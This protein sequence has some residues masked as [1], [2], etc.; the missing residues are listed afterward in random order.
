[1]IE[2]PQQ[3]GFGN[4]F[5]LSIVYN[6]AFLFNFQASCIH[7][8]LIRTM[9]LYAARQLHPPFLYRSLSADHIKEVFLCLMLMKFWRR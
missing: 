6:Y 7:S 9:I 3:L 8:G 4:H 5:D 2:F 1:M